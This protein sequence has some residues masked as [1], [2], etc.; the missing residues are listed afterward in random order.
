MDKWHTSLTLDWVKASDMGK[1][2]IKAE[3]DRVEQEIDALK[4][5]TERLSD[6]LGRLFKS[7]LSAYEERTRLI[8]EWPSMENREKGEAL[9][10]V[11]KKV[12]LFWDRK[13]RPAEKN[14][15]RPR[16]T[17]RNRRMSYNLL[18]DR[19]QWDFDT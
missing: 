17:K 8:D 7:S 14:P 9:R 15:S 11:F 12:A 4:P 13:F 2:K 3:M 6:R 10:K 16:K 19:I 5:K 18:T 1:A